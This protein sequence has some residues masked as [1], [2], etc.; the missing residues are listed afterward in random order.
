MPRLHL[1]YLCHIMVATGKMEEH[2]ESKKDTLLDLIMELDEKYP[3]LKDIFIPPENGIFNARTAIT[4][5][6]PG[7]PSR[8][9]SD[10]SFKLK[11]GDVLILW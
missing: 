9:L 6:R 4:L 10:P 1:K 8:G 2:F 5:S 11:E 3:G 7:E